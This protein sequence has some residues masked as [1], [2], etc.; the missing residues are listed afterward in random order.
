MCVF[1]RFSS[2]PQIPQL[3]DFDS[4][5]ATTKVAQG[6]QQMGEHPTKTFF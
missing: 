1:C 2:V 6:T 4:G 5:A 3:I